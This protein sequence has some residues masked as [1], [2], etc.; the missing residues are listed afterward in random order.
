MYNYHF[1][2]CSRKEN[3]VIDARGPITSRELQHR[4]T[5]TS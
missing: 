4:L 5:V 1:E 2:L 3:V